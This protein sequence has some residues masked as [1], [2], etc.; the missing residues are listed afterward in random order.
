MK[1][2]KTSQH[3]QLISEVI[4]QLSNFRPSVPAI[5]RCIDLLIEKDYMA[6]VE[7]Q[8]ETYTYIS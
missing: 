4:K 3:Q 6:R 5:K 7:G 8:K 1:M 2:R